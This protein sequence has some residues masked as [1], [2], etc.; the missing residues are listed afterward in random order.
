MARAEER[1]KEKILA[2]SDNEFSSAGLKL[3][4]E[5]ELL[6]VKEGV[7]VLLAKP[8]TAKPKG[9]DEATK[10][11]FSLLR[12]KSLSERVEGSFE[13]LLNAGELKRFNELLLEG[14]IEKFRLSQ[15]YKKA[16]Y[17]IPSGSGK[18]ATAQATQAKQQV[19]AK[20]AHAA[21]LQTDETAELEKKG[22]AVIKGELDARQFSAAHEEQLRCGELVG[23]HSFDGNFYVIKPAVYE[24]TASKVLDFLKAK[25]IASANEAAS[26]LNLDPVVVKITCNFLMENGDITEKKRDHYKY[27]E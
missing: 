10:R 23:L 1:G 27:I 16:V 19:A 8:A 7:W 14:A 26:A 25:K 15:K 21:A 2:F 5:Y 3:S 22:F 9:E 13:E 4:D 18:T 11:I 17:R 12:R 24:K 6:R 20:P